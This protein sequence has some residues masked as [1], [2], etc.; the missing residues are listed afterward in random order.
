MV[1]RAGYGN[2]W[3]SLVELADA[4][5]DPEIKSKVNRAA[6]KVLQ[7][8]FPG[9]NLQVRNVQGI[10]AG[11]NYLVDVEVTVPGDW[12]VGKTK[13]I[14]E[15]VRARIGQK[16]RGARRVRVRFL[17]EDS[18]DQDFMGEFVSPSVSARS[19]PEPEE[20]EKHNHN[21]QHSSQP[22]GN[23]VRQRK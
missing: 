15:A 4:S 16:V 13:L 5:F 20:E 11:Q 3:T 9:Q 19:S 22:N 6:A 12:S 8:Q 23:G 10:K 18:S 7:E 14:E 1:I 17:P 21:H 2:T